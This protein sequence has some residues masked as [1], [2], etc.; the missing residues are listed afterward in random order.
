MAHCDVRVWQNRCEKQ[1]KKKRSVERDMC[2]NKTL[3]NLL[4]G[5]H[6]GDCTNVDPFAIFTIKHDVTGYEQWKDA[7]I[8][9]PTWI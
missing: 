2:V 9:L 8:K 4:F 6:S 5:V 3:I 1:K 7:V